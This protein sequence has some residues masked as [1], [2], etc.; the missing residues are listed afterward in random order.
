MNIEKQPSCDDPFDALLPVEEARERLLA[1]IKPITETVSVGLREAKGRV[2]AND[3]V[4]PIAVPSHTNSA[5]D[6]YA[7]NSRDIPHSGHA[8]LTIKGTAWAGQVFEGAITDG[9]AVRIFTGA[10]VPDGADTVVIQ[11]HV[12]VTDNTLTIDAEVIAGRNVRHAGED[13]VS[14]DVVLSAGTLL[15][16]AEIGLLAS[17][18]IAEV[19]V[20]RRI[21]VAFF[22]T[23]DELRSL[24]THAGKTLPAGTIFDS[25]RY[26]MHA[27]LAQMDVEGIDLG[28]VRDNEADTRA[29]LEKAASIADV[30]VTS[31]GISAGE[32]DF[33][34]RVF[35]SMG[36]V[37]FWKLAMR[38]GRPLAFGQVKDA[39]FFGLPGNPVAVM[40]TYLQ[41][42][43]PALKRLMGMQK[44]EPQTL[45]AI[46]LSKLRKSKGRVEFQRGVMSVNDAGELC[47]SSTGKQGA[48][49]I[50][51]MTQANC[52]IVIDA[53]VDLVEPGHSVGVQ[54]FHGLYSG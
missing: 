8:Q 9:E 45:P 44:T 1:T 11:E 33:V 2:L 30:V 39:Y 5:M 43:K 13:V 15:E 34:T 21:K 19:A 18:G 27:L 35:H 49:R 52:L 12:K 50:S 20:T 7:I 16:A 51:S 28:V 25:N 41:F 47:V 42:V 24:D 36:S 14:G 6:G 54:P 32:A 4:S 22:S 29:A 37:A 38:P 3:V 23:G 10:V 53:D 46:S 31:G 48:G 26:S 17:L 40:V